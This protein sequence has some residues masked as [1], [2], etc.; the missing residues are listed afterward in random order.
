[1]TLGIMKAA[2]SST[3]SESD[4]QV[5]LKL[6]TL[7]SQIDMTMHEIVVL[8]TDTKQKYAA[9]CEHATRPRIDDA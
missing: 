2:L 3:D 6:D 5:H 7:N 4:A 1:M 8:R 9:V